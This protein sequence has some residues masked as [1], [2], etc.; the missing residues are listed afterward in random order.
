MAN[1]GQPIL[2]PW[3]DKFFVTIYVIVQALKQISLT[4]NIRTSSYYVA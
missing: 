3:I 1:D 2:K 4:S